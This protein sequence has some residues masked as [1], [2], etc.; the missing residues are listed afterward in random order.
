MAD[1]LLWAVFWIHGLTL[2]L[3]LWL[4][5]R[6]NA[7]A[8]KWIARI[9]GT[10][11]LVPGGEGLSLGDR[12]RARIAGGVPSGVQSETASGSKADRI[13][14]QL[15]K[16]SG[17]NEEQLVGL[18]EDY[19]G[20]G[21]TEGAPVGPQIPGEGFPPGAGGIDPLGI[22]LEKVL[23]GRLTKDDVALGVPLLV[24]FLRENPA[25]GAGGPVSASGG[26]GFW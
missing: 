24:R 16:R 18:A 14:R 5:L 26:G 6:L 4:H 20:Q 21:G 22:L 3:V 2:G 12:I 10:L 23:T 8:K 9:A 13:L 19:L 25:Q 7:L 15:A 1:E 17:L 11:N